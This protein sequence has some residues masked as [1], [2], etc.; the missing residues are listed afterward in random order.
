MREENPK[1]PSDERLTGIL[2]ERKRQPPS[3]EGGA[4]RSESEISMIAG[5]NHTIIQ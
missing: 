5:G 4:P 1:P 3:D 2:E